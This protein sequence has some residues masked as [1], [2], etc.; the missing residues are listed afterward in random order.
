MK[1]FDN[2]VPNSIEKI[3]YYYQ[4]KLCTQFMIEIE[5]NFWVPI[6]IEKI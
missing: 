5:Y 1:L 3:E 4:K 2:W 6:S